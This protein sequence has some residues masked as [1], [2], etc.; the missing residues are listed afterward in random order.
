MVIGRKHFS[1]ECFC[2]LITNIC[3][4]F[5]HLSTGWSSCQLS[6]HDRFSSCPLISGYLA[7]H[8]LWIELGGLGLSRNQKGRQ[9]T[10]AQ[11]RSRQML[12]TSRLTYILAGFWTEH[13]PPSCLWRKHTHMYLQWHWHWSFLGNAQCQQTGYDSA[14]HCETMWCWLHFQA[15]LYYSAE[16]CLAL[17]CHC[18]SG[19]QTHHLDFHQSAQC[20]FL[21]MLA[22]KKERKNCRVVWGVITQ[23]DCFMLY[24]MSQCLYSTTDTMSTSIHRA[25]RWLVIICIKPHVMTTSNSSCMMGHG[26]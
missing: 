6:L 16:L 25:S 1:F 20:C 13:E 26:L 10:W 24:R 23:V 14:L 5:S 2:P 15:Q 19:S 3:L 11:A 7:V 21:H 18:Q 12:M 8:W 9:R 22:H 17:S 4:Q